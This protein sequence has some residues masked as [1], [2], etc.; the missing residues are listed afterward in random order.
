MVNKFPNA[1][2]LT[3]DEVDYELII[4]GRLEETGWDLEAKCQILG[5]L[6]RN[7]GRRNRDYPSHNSLY[8]EY[9]YILAKVDFFGRMLDRF[10]DERVVSRLKHYL[11]RV[12]RSK[13]PDV[14]SVRMQSDLMNYIRSIIDGSDEKRSPIKQSKKGVSEIRTERER[15]LVHNAYAVDVEMSEGKE[16]EFSDDSRLEPLFFQSLDPSAEETRQQ[17]SQRQLL[18]RIAELEL[19]IAE[20]NRANEGIHL[21]TVPNGEGSTYEHSPA[22]ELCE[23][24][25]IKFGG[26]EICSRIVLDGKADVL[27]QSEVKDSLN[28]NITGA[29]D[30]L[31]LQVSPVESMSENIVGENGFRRIA[32]KNSSESGKESVERLSV[33]STDE[34]VEPRRTLLEMTKIDRD[35]GKQDRVPSI[36]VIESC[37]IRRR[38]V[39][40]SDGRAFCRLRDSL[41]T[42][43]VQSRNQKTFYKKSGNA[44]Y[45]INP[46]KERTPVNNLEQSGKGKVHVFALAFKYVL[47]DAKWVK[48]AHCY[49]IE[50]LSGK[51]PTILNFKYRRKLYPPNSSLSPT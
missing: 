49:D 15:P 25:S 29:R 6:F 20:A 8:K 2:H 44:N 14:T 7:D 33:R 16:W 10:P 41:A 24:C 23:T 18:D 34:I 40:V 47:A 43:D 50:D 11:M 45:V 35:F 28:V 13:T 22:D 42:E 36:V 5:K 21:D 48:G 17:F 3:N 31:T 27:L 39:L 37:P 32:D 4:R 26:Q 30:G 51:R 9:D 46:G 1:Y 19:E 12:A 38:R